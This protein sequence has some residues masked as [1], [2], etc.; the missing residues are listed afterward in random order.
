MN[1]RRYANISTR[2]ETIPE[3]PGAV[4]V[5]KSDP[6]FVRGDDDVTGMFHIVSSER[7]DNMTSKVRWRHY[8]EHRSNGMFLL[9]SCPNR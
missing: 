6:A 5:R 7:L 4:A 9:L 1:A 2:D 8:Q 3:V